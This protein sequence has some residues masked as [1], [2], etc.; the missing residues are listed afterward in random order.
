M[1]AIATSAPICRLLRD[2]LS[3]NVLD[4]DLNLQTGPISNINMQ[5]GSPCATL[6]YILIEIMI[7]FICH[8]LRANQ[9]WTSQMY[10]IQTFELQGED[11]CNEVQRCRNWMILRRYATHCMLAYYYR[12]S[13]CPCVCVFIC[14]CV[15]A[16]VCLC[17]VCVCVCLVHEPHEITMR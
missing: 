7:A 12:R 11:K 17:S 8:Y 3:R 10:S 13:V 9:E 14:V 1:M 15:C 2:I 5:I 4:V 6:Y 16:C